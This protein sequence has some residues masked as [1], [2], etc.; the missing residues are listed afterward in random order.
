MTEYFVICLLVSHDLNSVLAA[1]EMN[2]GQNIYKKKHQAKRE[3]ESQC[4][5]TATYVTGG[6]EIYRESVFT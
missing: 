3:R 4:T 1:L 2:F 6:L 5:Q